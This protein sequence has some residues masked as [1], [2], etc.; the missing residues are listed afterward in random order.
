M[1]EVSRTACALLLSFLT[2]IVVGCLPSMGEAVLPQPPTAPPPPTAVPLLKALPPPIPHSVT[3]TSRDCLLCHQVGAA[4]APAVPEDSD[5]MV[6]AEICSTCHALL[7][8]PA[9]RSADAPAIPHEIE[10]R[11]ECLMCHKLG[12]GSAPRIPDNHDGLPVDV[13]QTCHLSGPGGPPAEETPPAIEASQVPHP[14]EGRADCRACH[15]TGVA[16][17]PQFPTDHADRSNEVCIECHAPPPIAETPEA[18]AV[19]PDVPHAVE[20]RAD[21]RL[22]HETGVGGAT[23][24]PTNHADYANEA[25]LE[26]HPTAP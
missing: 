11:E 6:E 9:I 8:E 15:E 3:G 16:G 20:G 25:C 5:H 26:C 10:G 7:P 14:I 22:C 4:D 1:S 23:Q 12:I 18:E 13:C 21:C 24:F 17:A 2:L 19:A